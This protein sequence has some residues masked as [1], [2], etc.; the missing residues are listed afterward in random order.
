MSA[1][2]FDNTEVV[3]RCVATVDGSFMVITRTNKVASSP[4]EIPAGARIRI[5]G[6]AAKRVSA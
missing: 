2:R 3:A 6:G 4:E 1:R 5:N